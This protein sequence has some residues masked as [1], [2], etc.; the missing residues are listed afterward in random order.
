MTQRNLPHDSKESYNMTQRNLR[1]DSKES[2]SATCNTEKQ[3]PK[4]KGDKKKILR[5][6]GDSLEVTPLLSGG[7]D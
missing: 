7:Y 5:N 6:N 3:E 4:K 1:Y 2:F